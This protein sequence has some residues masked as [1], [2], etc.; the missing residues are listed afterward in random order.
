MKTEELIKTFT[1]ASLNLLNND[2]H[3]TEGNLI[4]DRIPRVIDFIKTELPDSLGVQEC[5]IPK[6]Y[7]N[8][9]TAVDE[10]I[11]PSGYACAQEEQWDGSSYAFKNFIWYNS[12]TTECLG[13]GQMWLSDTPDVPSKGFGAKHY[14]SMG[15][16]ALKNK[17]TGHRYLHVNTHLY[18]IGAYTET[19]EQRAAI[20]LKET[21]AL[22]SHIE[23]LSGKHGVKTVFV[24]GDM[25]E[26][27]DG[28]VYKMLTN[29]LE[30][31]KDIAK[32]S[33]DRYT[34]HCFG[35]RASTID[36]CLCAIDETVVNVCK[37]DVVERHKGQLL[38]DHG[39]ILADILIKN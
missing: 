9:R 8:M 6:V 1:V 13:S 16:A 28:A 33:T 23:T 34:F 18:A 17:A 38:S 39:A 27:P 10:G 20:R 12:N 36:Y 26:G 2:N 15:W 14:I 4:K 32:N 24:T 3:G 5:D 25:N 31:T 29:V 19:P 22:L 37:F 7:G 21:E 11:T 30:D 35:A